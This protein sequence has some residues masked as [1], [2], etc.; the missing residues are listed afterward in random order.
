M[1][2]EFALEKLGKHPAP[3][4]P[5]TV[6]SLLG[7]ASRALRAQWDT[8]ADRSLMPASLAAE[9]DLTVM[10]LVE[11]EMADGF[12][13]EL[14]IYSVLIAI[15][16]FP[17]ELAHVAASENEEVLLLGRDISNKFRITLDGPAGVVRIEQE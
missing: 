16:P 9:L 11:F 10:E 17:A 13:S 15:G 6:W 3:F 4:F 12:V 7:S 1:E 14:P 8:G 5:V 2:A